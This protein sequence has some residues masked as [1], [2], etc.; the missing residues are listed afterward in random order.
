MKLLFSL[1][2]LLLLSSFSLFSQNPNADTDLVWKFYPEGTIS[3]M[4][5][6]PDNAVLVYGIQADTMFYFLNTETGSL[7]KSIRVKHGLDAN[8]IAFSENYL[9]IGGNYN[10]KNDIYVDIYNNKTGD[11]LFSLTDSNLAFPTYYSFKNLCFSP[12]GKYLLANIDSNTNKLNSYVNKLYLWDL[13]TK[14]VVKKI[15]NV[16]FAGGI[17]SKDSKYIAVRY[18]GKVGIF[19]YNTFK[20]IKTLEH[21]INN[22]CFSPDGKYLATCASDGY[23][24]IWDINNDFTLWKEY[25]YQRDPFLRHIKFS[26]DSKYIVSGGG[27]ECQTTIWDINVN[28]L[29]YEFGDLS[30]GSAGIEI[31]GDNKYIYSAKEKISKFHLFKETDIVSEFINKTIYPNPS[32]QFFTLPI[33]NSFQVEVKVINN[34][35]QIIFSNTYNNI[36]NNQITINCQNWVNGTYIIQVNTGNIIQTYKLLKD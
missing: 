4:K 26:S 25:K 7:I 23:I 17:I 19:D 36:I 12:D 28:K 5:L 8:A 11:Y 14:K 35:G 24:K 3:Q 22:L 15:E 30:G 6:S 13:E 33:S 29:I 9:A 32:K 31:S 34:L 18:N 20:L 10:S 16:S 1:F 21:G 27:G 2:A